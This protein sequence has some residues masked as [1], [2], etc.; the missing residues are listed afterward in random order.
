MSHALYTTDAIVLGSRG[1]GEANRS[2]FLYTES[3]GFVRAMAQGVRLSK[4][5]LKGAVYT[6]ARVRATLVRG[7]EVWRLVGAQESQRPELLL[8]SPE[9][10]ALFARLA[11][12]VLRFVQGEEADLELYAELD[13]LVRILD[14]QAVPKLPLV[15]AVFAGRILSI[16][17]YLPEISGV[18]EELFEPALLA[19]SAE[20]PSFEKKLVEAINTTLARVQM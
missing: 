20:N 15:E 12:L 14:A 10:T 7:R 9:R 2:I 8:S 5:K 1:V 18:T 11:S 6:C 16:L 17:G 19:P 3:F 13:A 4:S